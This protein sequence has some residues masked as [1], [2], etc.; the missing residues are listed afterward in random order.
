MKWHK[1]KSFKLTDV[2][3]LLLQAIQNVK[4]I[5]WRNCIEHVIK[6]EVKM[7]KSDHLWTLL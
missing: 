1:S 3:G 7:C 6:E 2:K 5:H 4:G